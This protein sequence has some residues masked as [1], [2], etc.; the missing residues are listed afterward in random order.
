MGGRKLSPVS[1]GVIGV[2][3]FGQH[4]PRVLSEIPEFS[5]AGIYDLDVARAEEIAARVGTRTY[6]SPEALLDDVEAICIIVPTS[7][8][9]EVAVK[10]LN[11]GKHTF[12]EKPI[13]SSLADADA[14]IEA[15]DKAGVALAVGQIER[16]NPAFLAAAGAISSL[17][18]MRAER[19]GPWV[20]TNIDVDIVVDLMIHDIDLLVSLDGTAAADVRASGARVLAPCA[21]IVNARIELK[22]GVVANLDASRISRAKHR[23]VRLY[24]DNEY[25]SIDMLNRKAAKASVQENEIVWT[26]IDVPGK[27]PLR[28]ELTAFIDLIEGRE[29]LIATGIEARRSLELALAVSE[30]V[31]R[32][33]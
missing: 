11:A 1:I 5:L 24:G 28:E 31:A 20:G 9:S 10:A 26:E 2:G 25:V 27:E 14:I 12:V 23:M 15:A 13:A 29:S 32:Q 3:G 19:L 17:R 30:E 22:S 33:L 4:H 18:F 6:P 16:F 7:L 8:H 21:D